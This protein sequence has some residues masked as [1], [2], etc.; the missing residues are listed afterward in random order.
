MED[1]NSKEIYPEH[2]F[3]TVSVS[4]ERQIDDSGKTK[5]SK[6]TYLIDAEDVSGAEKKAMN[7]LCGVMG[8]WEIVSVTKS[9]VCGV[10]C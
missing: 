2:T 1:K 9:N 8:E 4:I 6:E 7:A 3:Y 5:K 10:V